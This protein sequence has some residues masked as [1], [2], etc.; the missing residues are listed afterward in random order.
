MAGATD[1]LHSEPTLAGEALTFD[2]RGA[3]RLK[4]SVCRTCGQRV[5]PPVAVCPE[6]LSESIEP[7]ILSSEGVLYSWSTVYVAPKEWRVPYVAGYVDL[8]EGV[9]VFAHV[10]GDARRLRMD[11]KVRLTVAELGQDVTGASVRSYAFEPAD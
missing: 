10:V 3:P 6:C 7:L 8:P 2:D 11:G 9:R 4:G 1:T 5:F